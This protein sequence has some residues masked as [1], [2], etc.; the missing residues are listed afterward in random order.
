MLAIILL[1]VFC[2]FVVKESNNFLVA[3]KYTQT[4]KI[5][6]LFI[7]QTI[8]ILSVT[9]VFSY[10]LLLK[11]VVSFISDNFELASPSGGAFILWCSLLLSL[12]PMSLFRCARFFVL[13]VTAKIKEQPHE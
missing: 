8:I 9:G 2:I 13:I 4:Y 6:L 1:A 5:I 12:V 11:E 7:L 10:F 3:I